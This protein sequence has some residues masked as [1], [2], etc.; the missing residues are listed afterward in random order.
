MELENTT[1]LESGYS[2]KLL[3]VIKLNGRCQSE[4]AK[5]ILRGEN[6]VS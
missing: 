4:A 6:T 1:V 2:F 5:S 3:A